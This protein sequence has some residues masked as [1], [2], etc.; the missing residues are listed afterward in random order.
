MKLLPAFALVSSAE[1]DEEDL[2]AWLRPLG[3]E[4]GTQ[5]QLSPHTIQHG[6]D[7]LWFSA[8]EA[9]RGVA[10]G[11]ENEAQATRHAMALG[12]PPRTRVEAFYGRSEG[13][14]RLAIEFVLRVGERW[15]CVVQSERGSLTTIADLQARY[16]AD[17]AHADFD[18]S[19]ARQTG[20]DGG[21]R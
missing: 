8:P 2:L 7:R 10:P 9:V 1:I 4:R 15:P 16:A 12:T 19:T 5:D 20:E 13:S 21:A 18:V 6:A 17:P 3:V 11:E 14:R